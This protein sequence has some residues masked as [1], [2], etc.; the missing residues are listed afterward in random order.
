MQT[1]SPVI[2]VFAKV[3]ILTLHFL[4]PEKI[5]AIDFEKSITPKI[6]YQSLPFKLNKFELFNPDNMNFVL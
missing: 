1:T 3:S 6:F 4:R 2:L 5:G